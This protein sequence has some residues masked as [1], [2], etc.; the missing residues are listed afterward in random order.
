MKKNIYLIRHCQAK[1][2][3]ADAELTELGCKQAKKLAD[4]L[5]DIPVD[6]IIS[7]PFFRAIQSIKPY[8]EKKKLPIQADNRLSERVLSSVSYIDWLEKLEASFSDIEL[9]FIGGES[10][11]E[12]MNRIVQ[13]VDEVRKS[14]DKN[15]IIVTHGNIMSL[16][17]NYYDKS[18]GFKQ[19]EKLSNP[20]LFLLQ[21]S[22]REY[23]VERFF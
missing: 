20:D 13:V 11:R 23:H 6:R 21:V 7:S 17:L 16:L 14:K 10:S 1:G 19:W 12:A 2:Q 3:E 15:V 5:A 9:K 4:I 18:F 8:A 22:E